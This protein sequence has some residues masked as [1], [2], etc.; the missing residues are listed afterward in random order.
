MLIYKSE[1]AFIIAL[2]SLY[3]SGER[4]KVERKLIFNI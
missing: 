3:L 1:I 2:K 4:V